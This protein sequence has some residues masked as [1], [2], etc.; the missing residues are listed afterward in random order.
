MSGVN[1]AAAIHFAA[2][3][4]E[5]Q[6]VPV[7]FHNLSR[8]KV[9]ITFGEVAA[10]ERGQ[11]SEGDGTERSAQ[12]P[13][14]TVEACLLFIHRHSLAAPAQELR[15]RWESAIRDSDD[16][17][18]LLPQAATEALEAVCQ[19]TEV[20]KKTPARRMNPKGAKVAVKPYV[21]RGKKAAG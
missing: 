11:G 10:V 21:P 18:V 4:L 7:G 20:I 3:V 12:K 15:N 13:K 6:D 9:T 14:L 1:E 8:C 16:A 5:S 19:T 17:P 2:G